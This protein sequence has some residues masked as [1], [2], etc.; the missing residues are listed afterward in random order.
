[1]TKAYYNAIFLKTKVTDEER[2]LMEIQRSYKTAESFS[3]PHE[4][5]KKLIGYFDFDTL[6]SVFIEDKFRD[7]AFHESGQYA[8]RLN[9]DFIYSPALELPLNSITPKDHAWIKVSL[10]FYPLHDMKENPASVVVHMLHNGKFSYK[11]RA[12]DLAAMSYE[13]NHWNH[14][15]FD[16]MTPFPYSENDRLKIYIWLRGD[17]KL[18]FDNLVVEAFEKK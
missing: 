9:K 17:K 12:F 6:N 18:Y 16:Y 2:T 13:L 3:N 15:S 10:S 14:V 4:Y 7:S 11:Y 1:M 5:T 8:L